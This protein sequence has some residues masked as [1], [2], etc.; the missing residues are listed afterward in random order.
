MKNKLKDNLFAAGIS[1]ALIIAVVLV[2]VVLYSLTA[3]NGW[4]IAYAEEQDLSISGNT[5]VLFKDAIAEG[6]TVDI[7]FCMP[8]D[9]LAKHTTGKD[10]YV[11]AKQ[12]EERYPDFIDL[13]FYNIRTMQDADGNIVDFEKYKYDGLG[14]ELYLHK[15]TVIFTSTARDAAG[16]EREDF[17]VLSTVYNSVPFVDFYHIDT[18]GYISAYNGEEVIAS[19]ILWTLA[20]EHKIAYFT[21]GHGEGVDMAFTNMLSSAGYYISML[22]LVRTDLYRSSTITDKE[23]LK[24]KEGLDL[25][26]AGLVI[27]SNPT[28]DFSKG[29][30]GVRAELD[31]LE[32]YLE[33]GGSLYVTLDPYAGKLA[34]LEALL[35]DY[36]MKLSVSETSDGQTV[37]NIVKDPKNAITT[38]GYTFVANYADNDV[39]DKLAGKT[40]AYVSDDVVMKNASEITLTGSAKPVLVASGSASTVANGQKVDGKG[41]YCVAAL[42]ER[43]FGTKTARIFLAS[44]VYLTASDAVVSDSYAN[45]N[46]VYALF[47]SYFGASVAP[48]GCA[49]VPYDTGI[50][51]DLTMGTARVYTALIMALPVVLTVV[52]VVINK[53]RK[54]R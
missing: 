27:I 42:S 8:E 10:V 44:G 20:D 48:Y 40:D 4:Y 47:D 36:G 11:T 41:G 22:D 54:N 15:G 29:V 18:E 37:R 24:G 32:Q 50:L 52:A 3:I 6:R 12:Y 7:I 9:E 21:I 16:L 2:N 30:D 17:T 14:N 1:A 13:K 23:E 39:G 46:F 5:D 35:S 43:V 45:R 38:D 53:R 28:A 49:V 19:R 26:R 51:E 31:K 33:E 34:N 25:D